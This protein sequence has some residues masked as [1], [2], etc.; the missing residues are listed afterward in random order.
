MRGNLASQHT[1][2][3]TFATRTMPKADAV[4]CSVSLFPSNPKAPSLPSHLTTRDEHTGSV[5]RRNSMKTKL[6]S[7]A[8]A[9][10]AEMKP[11]PSSMSVS[12]S[13][14]GRRSLDHRTAL[15]MEERSNASMPIVVSSTTSR[16]QQSAP[17]IL[18]R[19]ASNRAPCRT[20]HPMPQQGSRLL[21]VPKPKCTLPA[22]TCQ[23]GYVTPSKLFNMM[24]YGVDNQYLFM[25]THYLYIVD[26]R[27]RDKFNSGHIVTGERIFSYLQSDLFS[28]RRKESVAL[29]SFAAQICRRIDRFTIDD[30]LRTGLSDARR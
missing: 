29:V 20:T 27:T 11:I 16:L 4:Q 18:N 7:F 22:T 28:A 1:S 8:K 15:S 9:N 13:Q 23:F 25:L 10:T 26:C 2:F 24:G 12:Q 19:R 14:S 5:I 30:L 6:P 3:V 21:T 17:F